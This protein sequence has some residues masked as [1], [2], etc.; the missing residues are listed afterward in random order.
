MT[1]A[2]IDT[3]AHLDGSEYASDLE[4]ILQR[5]H[6]AGVEKIICAGQD[7]QTSHATL[8][9]ASH[10]DTIAPAVGVHPHNARDAGDLSW[11]PPLLDSARVVAAGE[12]GLD[13]HYNFSPPEA[14]RRV[15]AAQLELAAAKRL[16]VIVHCRE[17]VDDVM[18]F[19]RS[20]RQKSAGAVVHCFTET[21]EVGKEFI[22]S[23]DAYLGIGG[24]VTFQKALELQDAVQRLPLERLVL[25]TDCPFMSPVPFRGKRNEPSYIRITCEAVARLRNISIE[26]VAVVTTKNAR[27]L[28]PK[29]P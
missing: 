26:E 6:E 17:A 24:A 23:C 7:Q 10:A 12:M 11:L 9:L 5:A 16:P 21:Y 3:H 2:L 19:L 27:A 1:P 25:E 22:D 18:Q 20:H 15:F 28:F 4:L 29:L 8:D 13:Y 14:Q